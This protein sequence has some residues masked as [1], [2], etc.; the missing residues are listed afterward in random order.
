MAPRRT[1]SEN[2]SPVQGRYAIGGATLGAPQPQPGLHVVATPIGNLRD[3]TVRALETLAGADVIACE[4]TRHTRRLL[5]HYAIRTRCLSYHEHNAN[6]RRPEILALLD[7]GKAVALVSDAGTPLVSDPG[8]KLVDAVLDA[9]HDVIPVPGASAVLAA[10]VVAGLPTD[11]FMFAGFLPP[12]AG[13][14]RARLA[15]L[16]AVPATLVF[17]ESPRRLAATLADLASAWPQRSGVVARELTKRFETVTRGALGDLAGE[18]AAA[19]PPR[20]E[21]VVLVSPPRPGERAPDIDDPQLGARLVELAGEHGVSRACQLL[22]GE[23]G[24]ARKRLYQRALELL[25]RA[26]NA[27]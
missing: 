16:D 12:R 19:A 25:D 13:A 10:L 6:A 5:D 20:G 3:I 8:Y 18:F 26:G 14:R 21:I 24:I 7:A 17:Y 23:T 11:A 1:D 15:E 4:D 9:G 2:L 22:A 27:P